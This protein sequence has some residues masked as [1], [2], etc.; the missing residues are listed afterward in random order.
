MIEFLFHSFRRSIVMNQ[1]T[2]ERTNKLTKETST[3]RER[4]THKHIVNTKAY[5]AYAPHYK[6]P[7]SCNPTSIEFKLLNWKY[8]TTSIAA[9]AIYI[10]LYGKGNRFR[11]GKIVCHPIN[12]CHCKGLNFMRFLKSTREWEKMRVKNSNAIEIVRR[13]K[14]LHYMT[15]CLPIQT[16]PFQFNYMLLTHSQTFNNNQSSQIKINFRKWEA[17]LLKSKKCLNHPDRLICLSCWIT[18]TP[19]IVVYLCV[20]FFPLFS[21]FVVCVCALFRLTASIN[22]DEEEEEESLTAVS[23]SF[24]DLNSNKNTNP[25]ERR[26]IKNMKKKI[27]QKRCSIKR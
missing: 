13:A 23:K 9:A 20:W 22:D 26:R 11:G 27:E 3:Y 5:C 4:E 6:I 19:F 10:I 14:Q 25:T 1:Q 16:N 2:N 8:W 17:W 18:A 24:W 12:W 7:S 21:M 15:R